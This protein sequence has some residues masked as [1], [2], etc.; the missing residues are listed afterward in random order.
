MLAL[1]NINFPLNIEYL[2]IR[3]SRHD[4]SAQFFDHQIITMKLARYNSLRY[5]ELQCGE[6][7]FIINHTG[8]AQSN[9]AICYDDWLHLHYS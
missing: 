1:C 3:A 2:R 7:R 5:F 9:Q 8:V 6:Q 4:D